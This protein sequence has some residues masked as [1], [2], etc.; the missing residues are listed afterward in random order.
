MQEQDKSD[1]QAEVARKEMRSKAM[2]NAGAK[3]TRQAPKV[4][5][6]YNKKAS[7]AEPTAEPME[8]SKSST[9]ETSEFL[10]FYNVDFF[11]LSI[12]W[13]FKLEF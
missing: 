8:I 9:M 10:K 2:G 5:R 6:K 3:P 12:N 7:N 13:Y 11:M 1:A 4:P